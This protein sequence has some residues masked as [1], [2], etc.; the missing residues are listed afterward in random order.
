MKIF[1]LILFASACVKDQGSNYKTTCPGEGDF[2]FADLIVQAD[3]EVESRSAINVQQNAV[4]GVRGN[5][6][7]GSQDVLSRG[8]D[9]ETGNHILILEWEGRTVLNVEGADF[10]VFENAFEVGPDYN[11]MD[12]I[13]VSVSNDLVNWSTFPHDYIASDETKYSHDPKDWIG[14]AGVQSTNYNSDDEQCVDPLTE[15]S[16][17]DKFDL[18]A[19]KIGDSLRDG[20]RYL[21]LQSASTISN[22]DTGKNFV[23]DFISDGFDLDGV[24]ASQTSSR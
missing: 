20:F 16:G 13:V 2:E 19:L 12:H 18:D 24:Y 23:R 6:K 10:V 22:P 3:G 8:Y 7:A 1:L 11:F 15:V 9:E 4:N 21:R 14:F 5:R 17:G